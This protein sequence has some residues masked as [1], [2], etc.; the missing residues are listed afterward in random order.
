MLSNEQITQIFF[1]CENDDPN[2]MF[3]DDVDI[4]EFAKKLE[5][6]L[7][8]ELSRRERAKCVKFVSALNKDVGNAL[9][10]WAG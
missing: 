2:G 1:Y 9:K 3:A 8:E 6:F 7:T 5:A 10:N 4:F